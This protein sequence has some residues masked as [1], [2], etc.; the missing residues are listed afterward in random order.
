MRIQGGFT[1][2]RKEKY[3]DLSLW[4]K[5]CDRQRKKYYD[6][7]AIYPPQRWTI[8][9]DQM[10]LEHKI[11]DSELSKRIHHSVKAIHVRRSRL[12]HNTKPTTASTK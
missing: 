3:H 2:N 7:T 11:P 12:T 5:T 8:E 1:V 6:K 9:E 4:R 10:V